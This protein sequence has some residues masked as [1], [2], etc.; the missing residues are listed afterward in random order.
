MPD[1]P[2]LTQQAHKQLDWQ[3]ERMA[4]TA[5]LARW[6]YE[7]GKEPDLTWEQIPERVRNE[8][9]AVARAVMEAD[10][11]VVMYEAVLMLLEDSGY[12]V[13]RDVTRLKAREAL[14]TAEG[15]T[16]II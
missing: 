4:Q 9:R 5:R 6:R 8:W 11:W 3:V 2:Y 1:K 7:Y 12:S 15:R 10:G 14:L 16:D 13:V